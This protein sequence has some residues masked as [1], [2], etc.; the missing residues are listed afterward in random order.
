MEN[1][2]DICEHK[3]TPLK[4]KHPQRQFLYLFIKFQLS[5]VPCSQSSRRPLAPRRGQWR[6]SSTSHPCL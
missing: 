1:F 4:Q 2:A 3:D 5:M 6:W